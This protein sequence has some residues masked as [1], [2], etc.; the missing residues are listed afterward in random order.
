MDLNPIITGIVSFGLGIGAV[1]TFLHKYLPATRKYVG[2][3]AD[4]ISFADEL[5]KAAED[6][7]ITD[8]E[9]EVLKNK[10]NDFKAKIK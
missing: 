4:V 8:A 5:I 9:W 2:I 3:A 1:S 10:I 7:K 6:D